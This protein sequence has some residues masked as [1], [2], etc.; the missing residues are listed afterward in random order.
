MLLFSLGIYCL[1]FKR[2][3][4]KMIMGLGVMTDGIHLLLISLGYRA[5]GIAA[6]VTGEVGG[7]GQEFASRAVDPIPQALVLT[8]IVINIC[9]VA[10]ALS[11]AVQVYRH[12]GTLNP[13]EIR[14]L[15]G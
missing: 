12:Y 4:I 9:I 14:R 1:L 11:L 8:S 13:L 2:N 7:A 15:R 6:I 3:L 5:G 10:L